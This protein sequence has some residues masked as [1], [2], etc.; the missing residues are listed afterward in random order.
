MTK[1]FGGDVLRLAA[2]VLLIATVATGVL[3]VSVIAVLG[4]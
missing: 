2:V 1:Y 3:V 4:K